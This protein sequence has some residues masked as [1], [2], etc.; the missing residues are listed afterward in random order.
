[1]ATTTA[2]AAPLAPTAASVKKAAKQLPI[3][4]AAVTQADD[5]KLDS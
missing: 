3:R 1:M 4:A 5:Q 2:V